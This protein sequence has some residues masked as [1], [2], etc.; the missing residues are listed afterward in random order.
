[1]FTLREARSC[2]CATT[3][4]AR[5]RSPTRGS[6]TSG[7]NTDDRAHTRLSSNPIGRDPAGWYRR[8]RRTGRSRSAERAKPTCSWS[9][10]VGVGQPPFGLTC[11][12]QAVPKGGLRADVSSPKRPQPR[13]AP[14][15]GQD[16][17]PSLAVRQRRGA[18]RRPR[19]PPTARRGPASAL[20]PA[21]FRRADAQLVVARLY[22]F[23]SWNKL[24][25]HVELISQ[26]SRSPHRQPV[27]GLLGDLPTRCSWLGG[28]ALLL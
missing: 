1:V 5:T 20:D 6:T 17:A 15:A 19:A 7:V 24:R 22:G 12:R 27:G 13:A 11:G 21:A 16:A 3:P 26:Y 25:R 23:P 2:T 28:H 9:R 14:Q 10:V 4:T 18:R 8:C